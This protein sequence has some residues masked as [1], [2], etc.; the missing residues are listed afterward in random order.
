[1][2]FLNKSDDDGPLNVSKPLA[3]TMGDASKEGESSL[4]SGGNK[5][6]QSTERGPV[7][8]N[9]IPGIN[10]VLCARHVTA[11]MVSWMQ[12]IKNKYA[13]KD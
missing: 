13:V 7:Q 2:N 1:M 12:L 11:T 9:M 10:I 4:V 3:Q 8:N 6:E 5:Q